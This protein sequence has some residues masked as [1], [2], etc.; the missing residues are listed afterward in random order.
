VSEGQAAGDKAQGGQAGQAPGQAE[1]QAGNGAGGQAEQAKVDLAGAPRDMLGARRALDQLDVPD[2]MGAAPVLGWRCWRLEW[3][4]DKTPALR[5]P[6]RSM[7]WLPGKAQTARPCK[8]CQEVLDARQ[9]RLD[10]LSC[11]PYLEQIAQAFGDVAEQQAGKV[12][13]GQAKEEGAGSPGTGSSGAGGGK[14]AGKGKAHDPDDCGCGL[15]AWETELQAITH[16]GRDM[17]RGEVAMWGRVR[18]FELG[19]RAEHAA[20]RRLV[21]NFSEREA[22]VIRDAWNIEVERESPLAVLRSDRTGMLIVAALAMWAAL[23]VGLRIGGETLEMW[24]AWQLGHE[25]R[26]GPIYSPIRSIGMTLGTLLIVSA[27]LMRQ[28]LSSL[29]GR[30]ARDER[31]V[32]QRQRALGQVVQWALY[33]YVIAICCSLAPAFFVGDIGA[34]AMMRRVSESGQAR[35]S[36]PGDDPTAWAKGWQQL[37][38][39]EGQC[40]ER[41]AEQLGADNGNGVRVCLKGAGTRRARVVIEPREASVR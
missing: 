22:Q 19:W 25:H 28:R 41:S 27:V 11:G 6:H 5:S 1:G 30:G 15:N 18:R 8:K 2:A 13:H 14:E 37:G 3:I 31:Q 20:P 36:R 12:V 40:M 33:A 29:V 21:G 7:L 16:Q 23:A 34:R 35:T 10:E 38:Q 39:A 32:A 9:P 17:V 4:D 26:L 24:R